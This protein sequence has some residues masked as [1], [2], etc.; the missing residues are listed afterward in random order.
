ML[1]RDSVRVRQEEQDDTD[2]RI[3]SLTVNTAARLECAQDR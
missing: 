2:V 1:D 3:A